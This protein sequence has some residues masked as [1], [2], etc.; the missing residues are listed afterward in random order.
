M[1]RNFICTK[2]KKTGFLRS[3]CF[4]TVLQIVL[5][6]KFFSV[7]FIQYNVSLYRIPLIRHAR[8]LSAFDI[9]EHE[10]YGIVDPKHAAVKT[11]IV[12]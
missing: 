4:N 3:F 9:I 12:A 11:E 1:S 5:P 6:V 8:S 10:V 7:S 2:A